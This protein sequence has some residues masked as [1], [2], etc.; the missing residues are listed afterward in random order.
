M[1]SQ[2]KIFFELLRTC[3]HADNFADTDE[4]TFQEHL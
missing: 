4:E 3:R 1:Q 2:R